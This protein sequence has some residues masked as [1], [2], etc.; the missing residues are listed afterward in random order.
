MAS[1]LKKAKRSSRTGSTG[2]RTK[3]RHRAG[4]P[5]RAG[6]AAGRRESASAPSRAPLRLSQNRKAG[7]R[8]AGTPKGAGQ[9][10]GRTPDAVAAGLKRA[11]P[12]A[13]SRPAGVTAEGR[14]KAPPKGKSKAKG[15]SARVRGEFTPATDWED[16]MAMADLDGVRIYAMHG[17]YHRGEVIQHKVFGLGIVVHEVGNGKIQVSFQDGVRLL[18]CNWRR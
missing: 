13:A 17:E 4:R 10:R 2:S 18:V 16:L 3:D 15:T 7:K 1:G 12:P 9:P 11:K 6:R 14:A 8:M 5:E